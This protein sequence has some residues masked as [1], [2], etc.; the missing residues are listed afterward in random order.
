MK[1]LNF[2]SHKLPREELI[3]LLEHYEIDDELLKLLKE[4][5]Q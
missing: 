2:K 1:P 4:D 5:K 3:W